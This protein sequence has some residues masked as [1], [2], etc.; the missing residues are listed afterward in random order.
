MASSVPYQT[1]PTSNADIEQQQSLPIDATVI[2]A[3]PVTTRVLVLAVFLASYFICGYF[4][5]TALAP[6]LAEVRERRLVDSNGCT[7]KSASLASTIGGAIGTAAVLGTFLA[8][9]LSPIGPIAGGL[10]A[11][12]MGAGVAAGSA[13][14]LVQSAA[15]TGGAYAVGGAAG[16]A[17]GLTSAC[18]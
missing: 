3:P 15:M 1:I 10:F 11:S 17:A 6:E 8:I 5:H 16:A 18:T 14:A 4:V 13:M 7:P 12:Y 2:K 9:G